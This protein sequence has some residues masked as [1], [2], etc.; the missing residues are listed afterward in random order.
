MNKYIHENL[1]DA[2]FF[3]GIFNKEYLLL[4]SAFI[5][6]IDSYLLLTGEMGLRSLNFDTEN[7]LPIGRTLICILTFSLLASVISPFVFWKSNRF[8]WTA[9]EYLFEDRL[10]KIKDTDIAWLEKS[11]SSRDLM[12]WAI[13][14]SNAVA[15]GVAKDAA[16]ALEK[17]QKNRN[18]FFLLT[19]C[20]AANYLA[21]TG[22]LTS[23]FM[24]I[25]PS[26][27]LPCSPAIPLTLIVASLFLAFRAPPIRS[28]YIYLPEFN[29]ADSNLKCNT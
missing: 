8:L 26:N 29:R 10:K 9:I 28:G 18:Y 19:C 3:D 23:I 21:V 22:G 12:S 14:N 4:I 25:V 16:D 5:L 11:V 13:L 1:Y 15:F 7:A 6:H 2:S 27:L 17:I 24:E 20:I